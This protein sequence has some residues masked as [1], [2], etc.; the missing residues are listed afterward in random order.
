MGFRPF[1]LT[2]TAND[3]RHSLWGQLTWNLTPLSAWT[4]E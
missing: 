2:A 4:R 3:P 1:D